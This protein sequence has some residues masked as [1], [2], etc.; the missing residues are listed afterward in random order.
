M[1]SMAGDASSS[2][3]TTSFV[4]SSELS[5]N[6]LKSFSESS[7]SESYSMPLSCSALSSYYLSSPLSVLMAKALFL[8]AAT[9]SRPSALSWSTFTPRPFQ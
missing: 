9:R 6:W 2:L 3:S 4:S 1:P 5:S 7:Y 8:L